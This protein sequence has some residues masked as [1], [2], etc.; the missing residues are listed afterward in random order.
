MAAGLEIAVLET[1]HVKAALSEMAVKTDRNDA[2]SLEQHM[3]MS[4][5]VEMRPS[6]SHAR[7][8]SP[9]RRPAGLQAKRPESVRS[10]SRRALVD[11]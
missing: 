11:V 8:A 4:A 1:R 10:S 3:R 5:T 2:R 9:V 7:F 6:K